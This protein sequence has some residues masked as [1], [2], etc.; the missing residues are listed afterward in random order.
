MNDVS[1]LERDASFKILKIVAKDLSERYRISPLEIFN[2]VNDS[3]L[4]G[5]PAEIFS[6]RKLSCLEAAV[7][8]LKENKGKKL[9]EIGQTLNRDS[10]TA[11]N[12]YRNAKRKMAEELAISSSRISIP[13]SAL[14]DRRYSLLES[15][16]SYL[17][18]TAM[19]SNKQIAELL[20]R[21]NRTIWT[22]CNRSKIKKGAANE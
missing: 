12:T 16:C 10:R 20:S 19:L 7:K 15:I 9:T 1:A 3:S 14:R 18:E 8:Y 11:W 13:C 22:V 6:F 17:K 2:A 5:L 21:D 4:D